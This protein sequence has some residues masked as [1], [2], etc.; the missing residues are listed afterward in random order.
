MNQKFELHIYHTS[1]THGH[2]T[3]DSY[4]DN[5]P[6]NKGFARISSFFKTQTHRHQIKID[7]GDTIQGS[8]LAYIYKENHDQAFNP[9]SE[10]MN[11]IKY[12][13][14][15]PGNHD[16]NY[17]LTHLK[18][19]TQSLHA[20]TLCSNVFR[21]ES[22]YFNYAYAIKTFNDGP[23]IAIIGITNNYISH[24]ESKEV[25]GDIII[26]NAFESAKRMVGFI[27]KNEHPDYIIVAYHGSYGK[28]L[29]TGAIE[30]KNNEENLGYQIFK[31]IKAI[32]LL[33][34]GHEH[35]L[36]T[37]HQ[38]NRYTHQPGYAGSHV[39]H[40]KVDFVK[41]KK[42]KVHHIDGELVSMENFD[43]DPN[44]L[45]HLENFIQKSN[46]Q[47]NQAIGKAS[48]TFLIEDPLDARLHKH[49]IFQYINEVQMK[50]T[51]ATISCC[52]LG[53]DVTG[54]HQI[55]TIRDVLNTYVFPNT[56]I[57]CEITGETLIEALTHNAQFFDLNDENKFMIN[58][59]Y[60]YPKKELYNYDIFDGIEYEIIVLTNK[61]NEVK[62]VS[63]QNQEI[64]KDDR[65]TI[66]LNSYRMSGGGNILW[67]KKLK[68]IKEFPL[69][70]TELL[71]NDIQKKEKIQIEYVKNVKVSKQEFN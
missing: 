64:K 47:L 53:N 38:K 1:D 49:P 54:F 56:L 7:L 46:I 29:A 35:R 68:I 48:S 21:G 61:P 8:P 10:T 42:W 6:L 55:I 34:T 59:S 22:L 33:L 67:H 3:S 57:L 14:F 36:I 11:L 50:A 63:Y 65:F 51:G 26:E 69:D 52:S 45:T 70:I 58:P 27:K 31:E 41:Q 28:N 24:W 39:S 4:R 13:Y 12:D 5:N 60:L 37:I 25:L 30:A 20:K 19:F 17:G 43:D 32:D 44:V 9:F 2:L 40:T 71:I 15:I 18:Q 62:R 16:F 23:K 66:V